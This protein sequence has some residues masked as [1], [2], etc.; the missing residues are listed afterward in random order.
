M[1]F[2]RIFLCFAFV[3]VA[4]AAEWDCSTTSGTFTLSGDCV[5][6][7]QVEVTGILS[8]TGVVNASGVLP[9]VVGGGSNRLFYGH[10]IFR[11]PYQTRSLTY[12][13]IRTRGKQNC[14]KLANGWC[15][16]STLCVLD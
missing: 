16:C 1:A 8:L 9:R 5:V 4:L 10:T 6:S 14:A 3:G 7:S 12:L 2:L 15:F 13:A 11:Q